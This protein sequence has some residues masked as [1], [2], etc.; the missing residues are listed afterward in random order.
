G[1][2]MRCINFRFVGV[3]DTVPHLGWNHGEESKYNFTIP[4]A[5]GLAVHAVALNEHRGGVADFDVA[6]IHVN[7]AAANTSNRIERGFI[8]AHSDIGG[9]YAEGD[10]SDV[11]LMW[12]IDQARSQDIA[13][14][15][16]RIKAEGW[17]VVIAPIVHD[18]RI[19]KG[20]TEYL[21]PD[22]GDREIG[23][24]EI[25]RASCRE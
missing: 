16:G 18:S 22:G 25:G 15:D 9:G 4:D 20:F 8:G 7:A 14:D 10:L 1:G 6:S 21:W 17:N 2:S 12:M 13:F 24:L 11:T 5:V 19:G 3:W 23:Y